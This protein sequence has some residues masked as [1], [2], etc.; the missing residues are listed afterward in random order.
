MSLTGIYGHIILGVKNSDPLDLAR[1]AKISASNSSGGTK[2]ENI[3]SGMC[4]DISG[5]VD[6]RWKAPIAE[7][8]ELSLEWEAPQKI[9]R[10]ILNIDT[11][12]R[13]LT[14]TLETGFVKRVIQGPQPES[15][16]DFTVRAK[17]ANGREKTLADIKDNYQ[18]RVVIDFPAEDI[19][20]VT[21]KCLSTN[22]APEASIL[23]VRAYGNA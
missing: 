18:K 15:L 10:L 6:N 9:G 22:G 11:G 13:L 19:K 14:P 8:P 21:I 20:R 3:I 4:Y 5:A 23:E 1:K 12:S 2:P 7:Q 16:K 17:L